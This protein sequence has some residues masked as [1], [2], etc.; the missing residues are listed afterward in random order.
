MLAAVF[1]PLF[2]KCAAL[3][4][5]NAAGDVDGVSRQSTGWILF[6]RYALHEVTPRSRGKLGYYPIGFYGGYAMFFQLFAQSFYIKRGLAYH[7]DVQSLAQTHVQ[8]LHLTHRHTAVC[9][10]TFKQSNKRAH[11]LK[12]FFAGG[13]D[14]AAARAA[15]FVKLEN[16]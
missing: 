12:I 4:A 13:K 10:E 16:R 1:V 14:A 9:E 6:L 7:M 2:G 5:A 3:H 11:F 8:S 15:K